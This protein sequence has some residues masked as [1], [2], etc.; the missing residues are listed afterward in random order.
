VVAAV[1]QGRPDHARYRK[2]RDP[3]PH[4]TGRLASGSIGDVVEDPG[5]VSEPGPALRGGRVD[6]TTSQRVGSNAAVR[7]DLDRELPCR[8]D[9]DDKPIAQ[10]S[11]ILGATPKNGQPAN[12]AVPNSRPGNSTRP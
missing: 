11:E 8:C 2:I 4:F 10:A 12:A 7:S 1:E 6:R 5:L 3:N 9:T